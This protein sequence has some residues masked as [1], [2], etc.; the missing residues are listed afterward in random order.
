MKRHK[1]EISEKVGSIK[2]LAGAITAS[3]ALP[4]DFPPYRMR[5]EY[6]TEETALFHVFEEHPVYTVSSPPVAKQFL[7][8]GQHVEFIFQDPL[9]NRVT[10]TRN[11]SQLVWKYQWEFGRNTDGTDVPGLPITANSDDFLTPTHALSVNTFSP[12]GPVQFANQDSGVSGFWIDGPADASSSMVVTLVPTPASTAGFII[13]LYWKNGTWVEFANQAVT[14]TVATYT[15]N[16]TGQNTYFAIRIRNL[17]VLTTP[18]VFHTGNCE[19]WGHLPAPYVL[20]N[21]NS[22]E[23]IRSL[24]HSILVKN[25]TSPLNQDGDVTGVQPGKSRYWGSFVGTSSASDIFSV[26]RDYSGAAN[27]KPLRT[28]FYGY[29]KPTEEDDLR[30]RESFVITARNTGISSDTVWTWA[31]SPI[32]G[33]AYLVVAMTTTTPSSQS[34]VVRTDVSAEFETGNQFFNIDKPRA[35]P[36]D[37]RDGMEALASMQQFYENPIHWKKIL[38]TIGSV[39][40]IG[41]RILSLF[42]Q[43]RGAGMPITAAGNIL[44]GGFQ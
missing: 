13:F 5:N 34:I 6:S 8:P 41:G 33:T 24:G 39:A 35:E 27:T 10:Y 14:N 23:S 20:T 12:H 3:F 19:C 44:A 28:G 11:P 25:F 42:P 40:S 43:T 30:L 2:G 29:I 1:K 31:S 22:L 16:I 38:Q 9:R 7:F 21:A 17:P 26:V 15:Q 18:S 32:L 37:W 36:Q 4:S